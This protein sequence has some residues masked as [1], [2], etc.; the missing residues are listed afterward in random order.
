MTSGQ[1][2][3]YDTLEAALTEQCVDCRSMRV[4]RMDAGRPVYAWT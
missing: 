1:H 4:V 3:D 2:I